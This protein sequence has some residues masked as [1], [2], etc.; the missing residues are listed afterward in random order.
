MT[1][2]KNKK[3]T[4]H[5]A[6]DLGSNDLPGSTAPNAA[7]LSSEGLD[8][9]TN[10]ALETLTRSISSFSNDLDTCRKTFASAK[11]W[12]RPLDSQRRREMIDGVGA[13]TARYFLARDLA[14]N[15]MLEAS[16]S[17]FE[18]LPPQLEL[19]ALSA[20]SMKVGFAACLRDL[21]AIFASGVFGDDDPDTPAQPARTGPAESAASSSPSEVMEEDKEGSQQERTPSP[22]PSTSSDAAVVSAL[23]LPVVEPSRTSAA[24]WTTVQRRKTPSKVA[25]EE[26]EATSKKVSSEVDSLVASHPPE[27]QEEV[28]AAYEAL[29]APRRSRRRKGRSLVPVYVGRISP[30]AVGKVKDRMVKVGVQM[31]EV[32]DVAFCGADVLEI[33]V[34]EGAR[35]ELVRSLVRAKLNYLPKFDPTRSPYKDADY[36]HHDL[37]RKH[38]IARL[39]R[40]LRQLT[41]ARPDVRHH[42]EA[43]LAVLTAGHA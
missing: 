38:C 30:D 10:G 28:R 20:N 25:L 5:V 42:Y 40:S 26:K 13:D 7:Q 43:R 12:L 31:R 15:S 36:L 41:P 27:R 8:V 39:R 17:L 6:T 4:A 11:G 22:S 18:L 29:M 1:R 14:F 23:Q 16:G 3:A 24:E 35:E 37:A 33:L 9:L 19:L 34:R 2:K 32:R 21:T